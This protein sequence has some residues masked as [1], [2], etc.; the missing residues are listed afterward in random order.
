[1]DLQELKKTIAVVESAEGNIEALNKLKNRELAI[2]PIDGIYYKEFKKWK[3]ENKFFQF[4][5]KEKVPIYV[6]SKVANEVLEIL[7][8]DEEEIAKPHK[9]IIASIL[10]PAGPSRNNHNG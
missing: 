8:K 6:N 4:G 7:I 5:N 2:M 3:N 9:D 1:M 10:P